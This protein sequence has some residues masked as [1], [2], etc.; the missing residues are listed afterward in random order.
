MY[1]YVNKN[2]SAYK[3]RDIGSKC[4]EIFNFK[5][6]LPLVYKVFK[7]IFEKRAIIHLFHSMYLKFPT[8]IF[9]DQNEISACPFSIHKSN[10][11]CQPQENLQ[12]KTHKLS[13]TKIE[14]SC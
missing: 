5:N 12:R 2:F 4:R 8:Q 14:L 11:S 1:E 13:A 10:Y 9:L 3:Q 7:F 6:L